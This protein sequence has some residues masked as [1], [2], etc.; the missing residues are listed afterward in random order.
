MAA[1]GGAEFVYLMRCGDLF[2]IGYSRNPQGRI[3][4]VCV[5]V[6]DL[7]S[8]TT[9]LL[10]T[11]PSENAPQVERRL[12]G[13]FSAKCVAGEWF[14][15]EPGDV[16]FFRSIVRWDGLDC[17]PVWLES[18]PDSP[19][20]P[21][22]VCR[23]KGPENRQM[24]NV[25]LPPELIDEVRRLARAA[26]RTFRAEVELALRRHAAA[27]PVVTVPAMP[28]AAPPQ[29]K[30]PRGRPKKSEAAQKKARQS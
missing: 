17:E 25:E 24:V 26:G 10:F 5:P 14:R 13:L 28:D 6:A 4:Q 18:P 29:V 22:M 27:P 20:V 12:H 8:S 2:K 23:A 1:A 9:E 15:L 30:R 21:I 3:K 7:P 11:F 16:A 19:L